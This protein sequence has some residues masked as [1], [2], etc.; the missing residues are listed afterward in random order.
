L[1]LKITTINHLSILASLENLSSHPIA[2]AI[3]EYAKKNNIL[4][5]E[6]KDFKNLEGI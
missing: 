6:V 3:T 4:L 5:Q 2:H 1:P